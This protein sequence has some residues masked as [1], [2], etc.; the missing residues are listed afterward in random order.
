MARTYTLTAASVIAK[1]RVLLNDTNADVGYRTSDD[2]L[3]SMLDDALAAAVAAVPGL[4]ATTLA[5]TC[6]AGV[7]QTIETQRS[8]ALL[9]VLGLHEADYASLRQFRPNWAADTPGSPVEYARLP[10]EALRF[11]VRPP[12]VGGETLQA[13]IVRA[14]TKLAGNALTIELPE[15]FEPALVDYLVG[16]A[17]AVDDEHV[18]SNRA[19]QM[20]ASFVG[21][22]KALAGV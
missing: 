16:R 1:A 11:V 7:N 9:D 22:V 6:Q 2:T 4:F 20:V 14:P 5:H 8:G 17:E 13:R 12:A 21:T 3:R 10:G 19:A 18:N 15:A